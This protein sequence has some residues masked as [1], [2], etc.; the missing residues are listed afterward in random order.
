MK[1]L[2]EYLAHD[3]W[4]YDNAIETFSQP[5]PY[6]YFMY[7]TPWVTNI[8]LRALVGFDMNSSLWDEIK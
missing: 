2:F 7:A 5:I 6:S 8:K 3:T 1:I 4:E